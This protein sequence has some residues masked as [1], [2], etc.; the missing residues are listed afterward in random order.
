MVMG[1]I[2]VLMERREDIR[3]GAALVGVTTRKCSEC[4]T[5]WTKQLRAG[6][7]APPL[8]AAARVAA[9]LPEWGLYGITCP[10]HRQSR[11]RTDCRVAWLSGFSLP[12]SA[13]CW[14]WH[15]CRVSHLQR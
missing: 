2:V 10:T 3:S 15:T 13:P 7:S 9:G 5:S 4:T 14:L 8:M 1:D 11:E 6:M 12:C